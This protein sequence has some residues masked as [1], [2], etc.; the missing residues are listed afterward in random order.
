MK[1][2]RLAPEHLTANIDE[3]EYDMAKEMTQREP[4][5]RK[6]H[7]STIFWRPDHRIFYIVSAAAAESDNGS[8]VDDKDPASLLQLLLKSKDMVLDVFVALQSS[9]KMLHLLFL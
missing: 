1:N 5:V 7:D 4:F 2:Q 6:C 8:D 3:H 9:G